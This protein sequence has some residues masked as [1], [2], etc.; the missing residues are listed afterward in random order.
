MKI[1]VVGSINMDITVTTER[2]PLKGETLRGSAIHYIP[3]GKGAN[4]AVSMA[5]LG[6]MVEMFGCVGDDDSGVKL[7]EN[8]KSAGVGTYY[9]K[10]IENVPTGIALITVGDNDNAIV[11]VAGANGMVDKAY[12]D[13]IAKPLLESDIVLLQHE[14]PMETVE[15]II[16]LCAKNAAIRAGY[17][18]FTAEKIGYR[19]HKQ[20]QWRIDE[21]MARRI[22][23]TDIDSDW[24]IRELVDVVRSS[25]EGTPVLD[26]RGEKVT[27][28]VRKAVDKTEVAA[29]Y[30]F[31]AKGATG[32][33]ELLGK[34]LGMFTEKVEF[35][36]N[37]G[38]ADALKAARERVRDGKEKQQHSE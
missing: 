15:Y 32:A 22:M 31:N 20:F 5:K 25:K 28:S 9:I 14:I 18:P 27:T 37:I 7:L 34:H 29:V 1:S 13:L 38:I 10:T 30:Q 26:I 11:V 17:S 36:G 16:D 8:L 21:L 35:T 2:I 33:L 6:A 3:G 12:V 19:L 23:R 4:Q 24:V